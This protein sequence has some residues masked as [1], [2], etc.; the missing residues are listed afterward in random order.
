MSLDEPVELESHNPQWS[1]AFEEEALRLI[2]A[3]GEVIEGVEHIGSTAVEGL[4]ARPV[5][6]IMVGVAQLADIHTR[7][8]KVTE[9]GYDYFG[10]AGVPE[11]LF[12]RK[13]TERD[14]GDFNISVV[15]HHGDHWVRNIAVR[16]YLRAHPEDAEVYGELKQEIVEEGHDTL[17]DYSD[18]KAKLLAEL[19]GKAEEWAGR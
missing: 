17:L 6:D 2:D 14:D 13:R 8:V 4:V 18:E 15:E 11:R 16:D 7:V 9:L 12:F 10:E 19:S 5:V 3:F 1:E